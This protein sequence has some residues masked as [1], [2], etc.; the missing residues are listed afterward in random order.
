LRSAIAFS[1]A[2]IIWSG[3]RRDP[4]TAFD[5]WSKLLFARVYDER[6]TPNGAAR[7]FQVGTKETTA[8]VANRIH[9]LFQTACKADELIFPMGT[10][11]NLP[12]TKLTEVVRCL[13]EISFTATDVDSIGKAFEHFFGSVFRGELG[14]YFTM[15]QLARFTVGVLDVTKDDYVLDPTAGSGGF[16]LEALLQTWH[17]IDA[18]FS[19]Q[20]EISRL[21]IDFAYH[22]VFG[23]EIHE[24][25]ARIC[26]INL[27]LHHDGHSNIEASRSCLDAVFANHKMKLGNFDKIV[28]NPPFGDDVEEGDEDKLG[29]NKLSNFKVALGRTRVD[30]EQ[31]ILERAVDFLRP[32][33]KLGSGTSRRIVEQPRGNIELSRYPSLSCYERSH[34]GHRIATRLCIS[35]IG[36]PEQDLDLV[37]P[38]VSRAR[39]VRLPT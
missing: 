24:V 8:A 26:K 18:G 12:D 28:G 3:G 37:L 14:Q 5:E 20:D 21:R 10:R 25:L 29:T 13:E 9:R 17:K 16:L 39:K 30:S 2:A 6:N 38:E 11:I 19:G 36:R 33:G 34:I 15:R 27:L 22:H 31:V 7:E 1:N 23:I 4:L 32:G 35:K